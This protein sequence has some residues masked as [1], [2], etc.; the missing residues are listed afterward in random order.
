MEIGS[1]SDKGT[2]AEL[3]FFSHGWMGGPILVNSFDDRNASSGDAG[4]LSGLTLRN[5]DDK[6]PRAELDFADP[7][8]DDND[9]KNFQDAFDKDGI[10]WAW[11]CAQPQPVNNLLY[12]IET[13]SNYSATGVKDETVFQLDNLSS[14]QINKILKATLQG[15]L[16]DSAYI[17]SASSVKLKFKFIKYVFSIISQ[18][19]YSAV[20]ASVSKA[21]TYGALVGTSAIFEPSSGANYL[22]K[23]DPVYRRNCNFYK[24]YLG[25]KLDPEGRN[26]GEYLPSMNFPTPTVP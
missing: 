10:V 12:K 6:D 20:I 14:D 1:G 22:M 15:L 21:K 11:G 24:N 16:G 8:M 7:N 5:P 18:S 4:I 25:F 13:N 9:I 3:S 23:I 17:V 19:T 26:Y 2:L